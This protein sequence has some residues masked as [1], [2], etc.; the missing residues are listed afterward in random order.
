MIFLETS[1]NINLHVTKVQ[2]HEKAI[3][4]YEN[5]EKEPKCIS[6]MT[7]YETLTVL[8]KLKQPDNKIKEVYDFLAN[9]KI[10]TVFED[11]YLYQKALD[12]TLNKNKIGF[13]DNL[14]YMVMKENNIKTIASFDPDFDIFQDIKRIG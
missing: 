5:I 12:Y 9:S 14:S 4:L 7:I 2:N 10:I 6:E 3:K 8:R 13:F 1:F 11:L